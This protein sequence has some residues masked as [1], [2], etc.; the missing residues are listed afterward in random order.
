MCNQILSTCYSLSSLES[1]LR[2]FLVLR[3]NWKGE[4][5]KEL[6]GNRTV[7]KAIH[8]NIIEKVVLEQRFVITF[9]MSL[10]FF[11]WTKGGRHSNPFDGFSSPETGGK[12]WVS[13]TVVMYCLS[14][15]LGF[16]IVPFRNLLVVYVCWCIFLLV[17]LILLLCFKGLNKII[18]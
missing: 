1:L 3:F 12:V 5:Q 14:F 10:L 7:W 4:K 13:G 8:K 6:V 17:L 18:M 16:N 15:Y 2:I 11:R 9:Y